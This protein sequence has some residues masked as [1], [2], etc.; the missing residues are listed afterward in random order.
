MAAAAAAH[1]GGRGRQGSGALG[2]REGSNGVGEGQPGLAW[3]E[4]R[5]AGLAACL[6]R[7]TAAAPYVRSSGG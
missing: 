7:P 2:S 4:T 1:S 5:H 3:P 6:H